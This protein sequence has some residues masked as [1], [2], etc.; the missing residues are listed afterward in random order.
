MTY[1]ANKRLMIGHHSRRSICGY[2]LTHAL[3]TKVERGW[4]FLTLMVFGDTDRCGFSTSL[5]NKNLKFDYKQ[6]LAPWPLYNGPSCLGQFPC[7]AWGIY[8]RGL[9]L[10]DT[11]LQTHI[12]T[13]K[14]ISCSVKGCS[15][16]SVDVFIAKPDKCVSVCSQIKYFILKLYNI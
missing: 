10:S 15:S 11:R 1:H 9:D 2:M 4:R 16:L 12:H 5:R 14:I 13:L 6:P 7:S 3:L 8:T